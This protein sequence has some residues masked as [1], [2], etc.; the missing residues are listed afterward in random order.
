M[1]INEALKS[2]NG[3]LKQNAGYTKRKT[4]QLDEWY[5]E[6][7]RAAR[8]R[9]EKNV[10]KPLNNFRK[11]T[12]LVERVSYCCSRGEYKKRLQQKK[13]TFNEYVLNN[14]N[15]RPNSFLG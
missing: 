6:E 2:F 9:K 8:K 12:D 3:C 4:K 15:I 13:Q 14:L 1:D 10:G 5:D 11:S 7:C